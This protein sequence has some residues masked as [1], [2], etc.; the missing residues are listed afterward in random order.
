MD[1][2]PVCVLSFVGMLERCAAV[3]HMDVHGI[4]HDERIEVE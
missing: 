4:I 3:Q 2:T 1:I